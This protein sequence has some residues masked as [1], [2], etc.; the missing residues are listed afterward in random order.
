M[1]V[2]AQ[3]TRTFWDRGTKPVEEL[4]AFEFFKEAFSYA[5]SLMKNEVEVVSVLLETDKEAVL[6][7][8]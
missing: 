1:E 7:S 2:E 5:R 3:I 8:E 4:L 6:F